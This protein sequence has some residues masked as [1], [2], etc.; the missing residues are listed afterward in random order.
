MKVYLSK[1]KP[2]CNIEFYYDNDFNCKVIY[3]RDYE[4][5][6]YNE[7]GGGMNGNK[8]GIME[9]EDVLHEKLSYKDYPKHINLVSSSIGH[10]TDVYSLIKDLK[11]YDINVEINY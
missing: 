10:C 6:I 3:H 8:W 1:V 7:E 11:Q 4:L 5:D 9:H 2:N